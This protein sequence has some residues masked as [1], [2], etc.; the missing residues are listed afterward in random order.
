MSVVK[1]KL[2]PDV[3]DEIDLPYEGIRG[4]D[5]ITLAIEG[6][7]VLANLATLATVQPQLS[8]L[9]VA[10]RNWRLRDDRPTVVL[11]VRG[12]GIDIRVDLPRNVNT[13]MLLECLQPLF[14]ERG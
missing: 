6:V 8:A 5:A 2:P 11:T 7:A 12:R 1:L 3:L 4:A 13:A 14:E 10:I 9:V